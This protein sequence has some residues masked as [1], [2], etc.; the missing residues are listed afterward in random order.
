[1]NNKIYDGVCNI[2]TMHLSTS[3]LP[4]HKQFLSAMLAGMFIGLAAYVSLLSAS[5][6]YSIGMFG[7][8]RCIAASVFPVGLILVCI[9]G[10]NLFTGNCLTYSQLP[11]K[12]AIKIL[13]VS[14][15]GNLLGII[16]LSHMLPTTQVHQIFIDTAILK[17]SLSPWNAFI[18][19]IGCNILV[20]IGIIAWRVYASIILVWIPIFL[21]VACGFEHSVADM[22]YLYFGSTNDFTYMFY[23][24]FSLLMI[25]CGN[26]AGGSIVY[27][28]CKH[29]TIE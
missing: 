12:N 27:I 16:L 24:I 9:F 19:G 21:F 13:I 28:I 15:F 18:L 14:W 4:I 29:C 23:A 8:G 22:F 20:C 26:I 25:T 5:S 2:Q 6:L 7:I 3:K 11:I 10:V 1:M 17:S